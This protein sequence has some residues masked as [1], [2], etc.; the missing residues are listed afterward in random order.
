MEELKGAGRIWE[1]RGLT[2]ELAEQLGLGLVLGE[3][4]VFCMELKRLLGIQ[5]WLDSD[6]RIESQHIGTM[7]V[8]RRE[9]AA[10]HV[11]PSTVVLDEE[12]IARQGH[13]V[14]LAAPKTEF[15]RVRF[16]QAELRRQGRR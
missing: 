1:I 5:V 11:V 12:A 16:E 4:V 15:D 3:D 8:G 9:W 14:E 10:A 13:R 7:R 2:P 6:P